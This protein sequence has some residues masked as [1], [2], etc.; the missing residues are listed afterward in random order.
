MNVTCLAYTQH[1]TNQE[2]ICMTVFIYIL[3]AA[4]ISYLYKACFLL[5]IN[6]IVLNVITR[7]L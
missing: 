3:R 2:T 6:E 4:I 1:Q 7:D 5:F